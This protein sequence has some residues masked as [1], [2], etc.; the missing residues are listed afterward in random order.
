MGWTLSRDLVQFGLTIGAGVG[1]ASVVSAAVVVGVALLV[2]RVIAGMVDRIDTA[3]ARL[4]GW[5]K[6]ARAKG[7]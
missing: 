7:K 4:M 3:R 2:L 5:I 1:V 6:T